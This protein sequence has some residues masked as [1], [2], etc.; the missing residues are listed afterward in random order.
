VLRETTERPE[1]I[2]AG[3]AFLVGTKKETIISHLSDLLVRQHKI[4]EMAKTNNVYGDGQAA[5]RIV[6]ILEKKLGDG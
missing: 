6:G 5:K 2:E 1:A 4:E 3:N